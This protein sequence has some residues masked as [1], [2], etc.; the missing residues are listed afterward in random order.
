MFTPKGPINNDAK[1]LMPMYDG[2]MPLSFTSPEDELLACRKTA[3]LGCFLNLSPV[4]DVWGPDTV[5]LLNYITVNRDYARLKVGK[6]RHAILCNDKGQMLADGV[7][8]RKD[9][10]VYRTYWLAPVI[11]YYVDT[12]GLDVHGAWVHDEF[13]FQI[14]GPKSLEIM[15][16]ACQEDLHDLKFAQ[17]KNI[18]IAGIPTTIHRLGMSG[19]LAYEM[20]GAFKDAETV[21]GAIYDAGVGYG[22]RKLAFPNYC[23]NHTQ[24]GYPNQWIHFWYPTLS[25]GESMKKYVEED[26]N[27]SPL[28]KVYN[29]KGSA[30]DDNEN[31]FVTPFDVGWDYLI[32]YDHDFIGKDALAKIKENQP[33]KPV[34]LEWNA[35][36]V[37]KVFATQ[38]EGTGVTPIDDITSTGDGGEAQFVMSK[39]MDGDTM[40]GVATG[41]THDFYH[42]KMISLAWIK[43]ADAVDG[44]E[45]TVIWGTDPKNQQSIRA[46]VAQFPY[47]NEELRNETFDVE[48][49]PHIDL[50]VAKNSKVS[51]DYEIVAKMGG[52][53]VP[54]SFHYEENGSEL[55]GTATTMGATADITD[56]TVTGNM[57]KH[58][59]KMK[60]PVGT[61]KVNVSGEVKGDEIFGKMK[62]GFVSLDFSGKRIK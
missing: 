40:V 61:M 13:F 24:A 36:D 51:G 11:S 38:F 46:T 18:V 39:V 48:K 52:K 1:A 27:M 12:L 55:T 30:A 19:C 60:T 34:T 6:S 43:S 42:R 25:S 10:N 21:Y 62:A 17:N 50:N 57:F 14:D 44:K 31:A 20:H 7:L 45:L 3:W 16:K 54:G 9:E 33:R 56:G 59:M 58:K 37:G 47:Y 28:M 26:P 8:M 15:E 53:D 49:I 2:Y 4:Y 29:F 23:R 35:E 22:I 32:N 5:K 41:R